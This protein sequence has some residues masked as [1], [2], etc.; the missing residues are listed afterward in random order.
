MSQATLYSAA[1]GSTANSP[2]THVTANYTLIQ[3]EPL[4]FVLKKYG[5]VPAKTYKS[6]LVEFYTGEQICYAKET[7][8]KFIENINPEKW[9]RPPKRRKDSKD[10][11]GN[12]L[13]QDVNDMLSTVTYIDENN[14]RSKLPTFVAADP[15]LLPSVKLT[16]G[17]QNTS[18]MYFE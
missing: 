6:I 2:I 14:V 10:N 9:V 4:C 8:I 18:P 17:V 7:M 13:R 12:K 1:E 11:V 3:C 16:D 15:D 5:Q